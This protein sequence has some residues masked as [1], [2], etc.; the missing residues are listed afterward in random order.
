METYLTKILKI[1][2]KYKQQTFII[3][4]RRRKRKQKT[5]KQTKK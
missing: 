5:S 3:K 2:T 1:H 4:S